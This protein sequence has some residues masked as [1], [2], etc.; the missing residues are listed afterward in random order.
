MAQPDQ[1]QADKATDNGTKPKGRLAGLA[2][3]LER[4]PLAML[5]LGFS[6]GLP[7]LLIY[8]TLSAWLRD[9]GVSLEMIGFLALATLVYALK[10]VWAPLLDRTNIPFL[11]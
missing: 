4:R 3:Y 6:A 8:D 10:F 5:L 1:T 7:F 2:V 11:S 9:S